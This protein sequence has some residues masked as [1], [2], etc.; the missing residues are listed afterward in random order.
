MIEKLYTPRF[1]QPKKKPHK[2]NP[3]NHNSQLFVFP[4]FTGAAPTRGPGSPP[5]REVPRTASTPV[6]RSTGAFPGP[7]PP[8]RGRDPEPSQLARRRRVPGPRNAGCTNGPE[9]ERRQRPLRPEAAASLL[10]HP[11][12][13]P[14]LRLPA[15]RR[16]PAR[17]GSPKLKGLLR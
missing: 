5:R 8:L 9:R 6:P 4:P 10:T 17:R 15:E 14:P 11:R 3:E 7:S 12:A 13:E 2:K 16:D 1:L